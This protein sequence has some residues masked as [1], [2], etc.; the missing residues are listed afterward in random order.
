MTDFENAINVMTDLF[1]KDYQFALATCDNNIPSLR[2]VD[3]YFDGYAF[4]IV[5]YAL[6]QKVRDIAGNSNVS[7][8]SRRMY[9][10][11]GI[12]DN[13]GHPLMPVNAQIRDTLTKAFE[14]WY[15]MHNDESDSNMCYLKIQPAT[16][17]FHKDGTGYKINFIEKTVE[18]FPFACDIGYTEE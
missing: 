9:S 10:F 11:S 14:P 1:S 16:G 12:A 4:Y 8:Y 6:S 13:I 3:T 2:F 5:T 18:A 7:L 17:F 15:F